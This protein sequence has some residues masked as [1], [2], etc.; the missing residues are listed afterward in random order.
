MEDSNQRLQEALALLAHG[1][2]IAAEA[3]ERVRARIAA[4]TARDLLVHFEGAQI[5]LS[6]IIV[7][8]NGEVLE[9]GQDRRMTE[10]EP[11]EQIAR[12]GLPEPPAL[13]KATR[14]RGIG[15]QSGCEQ[16]MVARA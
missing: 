9:E 7:E 1:C 12:W 3:G 4:E 16:G 15:R 5:P 2:K 8:G 14:Q 11:F 10:S 13:A 6:L